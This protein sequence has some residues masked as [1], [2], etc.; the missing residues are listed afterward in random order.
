MFDTFRGLLIVLVLV[1]HFTRV[2]GNFSQASLGGVIYITLIS[3]VNHALIFLS[4]FFSKNPDRSNQTTFHTLMMTYIIRN[5]FFYF[6]ISLR[7]G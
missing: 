1:L 2:A 5:P 4:G 3:N 7:N 6:V